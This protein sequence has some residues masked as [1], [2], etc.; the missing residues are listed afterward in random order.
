MSP[1]ARIVIVAT[2]CS[3]PLGA[4]VNFDPVDWMSGD[5]FS[6]KKPLPGERKALFPEGVPGVSKGVP[7][8]LVKGNQA[9][10]LQDE[11]AQTPQVLLPEEPKPKPKA[12]PKPKVVQQPTEPERRPTAV[13]VRPQQQP[14]QQQQ[15]QPQ[16]PDPP[17]QRPAQQPA[18][19]ARSAR[20]DA[21]GRCRWRAVARSA[22]AALICV[23]GGGEA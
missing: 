3:L 8:D 17:S 4:C 20:A 21:A 12:K 5:W 9:T 13:T 7:A 1:F 18:A 11:Q 10:A 23:C 19:V 2:V 22:G 16:W 15:Q 6:N 14:Q